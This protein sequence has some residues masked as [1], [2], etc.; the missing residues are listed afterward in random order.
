MS[1]M[2]YGLNIIF[3][4]IDAS[5]VTAYGLY[6]KVQ[7]FVLFAAFGLRDA[8][9]PIVSFNYGL[10]SKS[11]VNTAIKCGISYTLIIMVA[12]FLLLEI[13]AVPFSALFGLSGTTQDLCIG[14]M[15]IVSV[16]FIFAGINIALQGVFQALE[17][18]MES[19]I[20]SLCHQLLFVLPIAFIF[21]LLARQSMDYMWLVWSTFII[22]EGVS[23]AIA[24]FFL[25]KVKHKKI[26]LLKN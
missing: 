3:G 9:T 23:A 18:G 6:Y 17:S 26:A 14:A 13:F 19:L 24:Y 4:K 16:S 15:R 21:S 8:I 7:Q 20:I 25:N 11:R 22:A 5:V 2:T 10:K 12:G 1:V